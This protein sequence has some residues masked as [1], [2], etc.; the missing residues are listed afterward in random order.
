MNDIYKIKELVNLLNEAS[1]AYYNSGTPI[2]TDREFDKKLE[3]LHKLEK[4]TG[5]VMSNSPTNNVGAPALTKLNKVTH[6]YKPMLSLEKVH[7]EE[8]I[9]K[10]ANMHTLVAMT[11]LDG[12]STRL[13]YENG[14]L[15]RGE[16]R[17]NGLGGS[18][19]SM[20]VKQFKNVPLVINKPGIYVVDGEAI[21]TDEDFE[22][23]NAALPEGVDKF[24]NSRNLASGTL[25]LLDTAVVKERHLN[26]ILWD[27]IVGSDEKTFSARIKQAK[28]LGF[29]TVNTIEPESAT[30]QGIK[31]VNETILNTAKENGHPCDGVV[32][33]FDDIK[34]GDSLG[35]T[36][37]H[38]CNA[39][40]YKPAQDE[41]GTVLRD[42]EWTMGKTGSLCPVAIFDPVEI[43]GTEVS[44]ASVHNISILTDLELSIGDII[45]VYKANMI[46]PQI[47]RNLTAE[48]RAKLKRKEYVH[49]PG[50][51]PICGKPTEIRKDNDTLVLMCTND[52]C[53]GKLLGRLSHFVSKNAIDIDGMSEATLEFMI[54]RFGIKT[55]KDLYHIPFSPE[56]KK[57]WKNSTGFGSKSVDKLL[58]AIEQSRETTLERFIYAQSIPLIGRSASKDIAKFC[59]GNFDEFYNILMLRTEEC[60]L[61]MDGFGET[62]LNSLKVWANHHLTEFLDLSK[63]FT[64]KEEEQKVTNSSL[65]GLT[66]VITG[67]L[68][69]F[70]NRE[71]L[72]DKIIS[73]GGK[74]SG[75]V[76]A[77]TSYLINNDINSTSGKNAKAKSLSVPIISESDFLNMINV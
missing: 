9:I 30:I 24:K 23:I 62:M 77:K 15:I 20:H 5:F 75:S 57:R 55:F 29:T 28:E 7:T 27:V 45:T 58:N 16:T 72:T 21:I 10:F 35:Q 1:D 6:E 54:T 44:R 41:Y 51:C 3:E 18:D 49:V 36:S 31:K 40:A 56:V 12:L 42:I 11:K 13:T 66:F 48:N 8:E 32:W 73:L 61:S 25:A 65:E 67:T 71:E 59:N 60:F 34:Y 69:R 2:M 38:F 74:V 63:E 14:V 33:K 19:I 50:E 4:E 68:E 76:S 39:I 43:D 46:I 47:A 26:F 37:H 52:E 22:R 70:K 53:Q 64:F 17:G